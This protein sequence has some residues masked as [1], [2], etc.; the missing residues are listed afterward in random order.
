M[1]ER[2][3]LQL[4][5]LEE[6][7][8]KAYENSQIYKDKMKKWHDKHFVKKTF[9]EGDRVLIFNLRLKLFPGKLKYRWLGPYSVI[10]V[11]PYGAIGLRSDD[12]QQFKV[13]G[14]CLKHY[15]GERSILEESIQLKE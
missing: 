13:N 3:L 6:F 11:S 14:Q 4:N 12:G 15:L 2:Q 7:Q 9:K 10:S 5:E 8:N 1:G